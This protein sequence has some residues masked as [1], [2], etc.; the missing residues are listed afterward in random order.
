MYNNDLTNINSYIHLTNVTSDSNGLIELTG[1]TAN[2]RILSSYAMK[3][4][5]SFTLLP[6]YTILTIHSNSMG[7]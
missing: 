1:I 5:E 3:A 6:F 2:D 7:F 4:N